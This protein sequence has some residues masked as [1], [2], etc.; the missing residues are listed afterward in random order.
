MLIRVVILVLLYGVYFTE[1]F[2]QEFGVDETVSTKEL[3]KSGNYRGALKEYKLKLEKDPN[4]LEYKH[5]I[6]ACY[7]YI[8]DDK[9]KAIPF[10]EEVTEKDP[11]NSQAIFDL[12]KAFHL[13]AKFEKAI[14]YYEEY[15]EKVNDPLE[16]ENVLRQIEMCQNGRELIKYPIDITFENLG[17]YVNSPYP[18]FSP[19][20]PEDESF[21]IF[22][23]RRTENRGNLFDYDGFN[24]S[25]IYLSNVKKG[26]FSRSQN[27][28]VINTESEEEAAGISPDGTHILV[29]VDDVFQNIYGNIFMAQ[30]RGRSF[31]SLKSIGET[32]NGS[33]SI[34]TSACLTSDGE[35]LFFASDRKGG[36]GGTD[37]YYA[38]K[39]PDGNWSQPINIGDKVNTKYNEDY[40]SILKDG[41]TLY[42]SSEG[43][44]SMGGYDLFRSKWN[45]AEEAWGSSVNMG[46]PINT[47]D[48]NMNISFS[49]Q[50]DNTAEE[51]RSKYAYIAAWRAEGLG[52]LDIYRITFNSVAPQLTAITGTVSAKIPIDNSEYKKFFHYMKG[53]LRIALPEE[54]HPWIVK[55]WKFIEEKEVKVRPGYEYKTSLFF[56][57]E[58]QKKIYSSKKYPKGDPSYKFKNAKT[59]LIKKKNYVAQK[60]QYENKL[61]PDATIHITDLTNNNTYNYIPG[62]RGNYIAILS[63]G[64]YKIIIEADDYPSIKATIILFDK[65]NFKPEIKKDFVF[66]PLPEE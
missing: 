48:D 40:P 39:L 34:E 9:S 8:N 59:N 24:P 11:A 16:I 35:T 1:S 22:S 5:K 43:H 13:I 63:P 23:S 26:V 20:V 21:L 27:I 2:S 4:N 38:T 31:Q 51:A 57:K 10:L 19:F 49:S 30:R 25:D 58:G 28:G 7:L 47:P 66:V 15:K 56:E 62:E 6:G 32:V 65:G 37:I 18:D 42:F 60:I 64:K 33:T 41:N 55:S 29:Y 54:C 14:K 46:Y 36:F 12:G 53:N 61:V 17:R 44:N 50:W 45:A 52:D 3:F